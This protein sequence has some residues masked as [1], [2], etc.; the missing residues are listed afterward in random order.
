MFLRRL[1][2]LALALVTLCG[3]ATSRASLLIE[4]NTPY[5]PS[6]AQPA[7]SAR[8]GTA[9]F[10]DVAANQVKLTVSLNLQV[11]SEFITNW[12]FNVDSALDLD[13]T[14]VSLQSGQAASSVVLDQNEI[15]VPGSGDADIRFTFTT[16]NNS[17]RFNGTELAVYLFQ[18]NG[19]G[20]LTSDSFKNLFSNAGNK[21]NSLSAMHVQGLDGGG[22]VHVGGALRTRTTTAVPEPSSL[23]LAGLG[24]CGIALTGVVRRRRTRG[25]D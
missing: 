4:M 2:R 13:Q 14:L 16:A 9:T 20:L 6:G 3:V 19:P 10:E 22:S 17:N 15:N 18:N 7:G 5:T 11:T 12:Y 8:F 23:V 25:H 21:P 24:V 1:G